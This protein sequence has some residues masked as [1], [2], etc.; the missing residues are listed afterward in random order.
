[1]DADPA[2]VVVVMS[3]HG[4]RLDLD[5]ETDEYFRNFLAVRSPGQPNVLG[6]EPTVTGLLMRLVES[7]APN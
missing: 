7:Y 4:A 5:A 2:A 3:D 6:N 1:V